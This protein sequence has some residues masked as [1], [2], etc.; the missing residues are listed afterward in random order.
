MRIEFVIDELV[1]IGFE[2]RDRHRIADAVERQ[3]ASQS[4]DAFPAMRAAASGRSGAGWS[5]RTLRAPDVR[6]PRAHSGAPSNGVSPDAIGAGGGQ[7]IVEALTR[8]DR[9][10]GH[11]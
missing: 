9:G 5:T 6:V 3:L 10:P 7:S 8:D 4:A 11:A 1:L 2:P